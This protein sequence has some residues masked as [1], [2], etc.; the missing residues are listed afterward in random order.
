[1]DKTAAQIADSV[2]AK[3]AGEAQRLA[4]KRARERREQQEVQRVQDAQEALEQT[5][6][7]TPEQQARHDADMQRQ[8]DIRQQRRADRMGFLGTGLGAN[9]AELP[10]APQKREAFSGGY[11][12][13]TEAI[14]HQYN[15]AATGLSGH[16][17]L[18]QTPQTPRNP[19]V[20]TA[21]RGPADTGAS[22]FP[23]QPA[24]PAPKPAATPRTQAPTTAPKPPSVTPMRQQPAPA[25]KPPQMH[26][27]QGWGA[28]PQKPATQV[29]L[30]P[31]PAAQ[32]QKPGAQQQQRPTPAAPQQRQQQQQPAPTPMRPTPATPAQKPPQMSFP[33]G[34]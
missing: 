8:V 20:P 15:A 5:G 26:T 9:D 13:E 1:M 11:A 21:Y 25:Q 29:P 14:P 2:L 7:V 17:K 34:W 28:A 27:P 30:R 6:P 19:M 22:R 10:T 24:T 33:K 23:Q 3:I 4:N 31:T 12:M 16:G 32:P 18:T